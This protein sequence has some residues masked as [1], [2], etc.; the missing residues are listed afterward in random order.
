MAAKW[1]KK[2]EALS[3]QH[4]GVHC[5]S[6]KAVAPHLAD[7]EHC[8]CNSKDMAKLDLSPQAAAPVADKALAIRQT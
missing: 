4:K 3:N 2:G 1:L 5:S 8:R 6:N 7:S